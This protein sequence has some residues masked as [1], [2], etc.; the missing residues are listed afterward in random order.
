MSVM[1]FPQAILSG[2]INNYDAYLIR[3]K[4]F[5]AC[6]MKNLQIYTDINLHVLC[7]A[8]C[9]VHVCS[10]QVAGFSME[11]HTGRHNQP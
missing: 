1:S 7:K 10:Q 5:K 9:I 4:L 3:T 11:C 8:E 6:K 2:F